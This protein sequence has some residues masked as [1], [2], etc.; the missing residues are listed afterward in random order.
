MMTKNCFLLCWAWLALSGTICAAQTPA[1]NAPAAKV[2]NALRDAVILI[3]RHAEKPETGVELALAGVQRAHA[4]TNYFRNFAVDSA[5][6]HLDCLIAAADSMN[7][8]RSRLTLEPLSQSLGLPLDLRY[9]DKEA[10]Q[11]A[12]ELQARPHGKAI[13]IAWHHGQ[14]PALLQALGADPAKLLPGGAWP[15][16]VFCWVIQLRYDQEGRLI[17]GETKR[18]NENLMP[19]DAGKK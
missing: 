11:L 8:H 6:L 12:A 14:I 18:V 13:L 19:G 7:S 9:K 4:Y 1:A 16:D 5:P 3:V 17:P 2:P 15:D 10:A